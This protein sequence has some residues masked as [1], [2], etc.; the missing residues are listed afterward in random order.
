MTSASATVGRRS[1]GGR[2]AVGVE[3]K[4]RGKEAKEVEEAKKVQGK[5][6]DSGKGEVKKGEED[7]VPSADVASDVQP[8]NPGPSG[9]IAHATTLEPV[10]L[11]ANTLVDT[12]N[13][14]VVLP[15]PPQLDNL[16][17][18]TD[19]PFAEQHL[20]SP[21][22]SMPS[23]EES[24]VETK[25]PFPSPVDPTPVVTKDEGATA[26]NSEQN[27]VLEQVEEPIALVQEMPESSAVNAE[28][29][30]PNEQKTVEAPSLA[31]E[32]AP[33][34]EPS[35][36]EAAIPT[37]TQES[38]LQPL[39]D[40]LASATTTEEEEQAALVI[41]HAYKLHRASIKPEPA[42]EAEGEGKVEVGNAGTA[43]A[44]HALVEP[45]K[46]EQHEEVHGS[47]E[48]AEEKKEAVVEQVE[49]TDEQVVA[50]SGNESE[51]ATG[52]V[53][54]QIEQPSANLAV[55]PI[56]EPV[57]TTEPEQIASPVVTEQSIE[58]QQK[59]EEESPE[60]NATE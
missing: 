13:A 11:I 38:P 49:A 6:T 57:L 17:T 37:T 34:I 47:K 52:A 9:T 10:V 19:E 28:Q 23:E 50:I 35:L 20:L 12:L 1:T 39:D 59:V 22:L 33:P 45:K 24:P 14:P 15:Q 43:E 51:P 31:P 46:E 60:P 25:E 56:A 54:Q 29:R 36:L 16:P 2:I 7:A 5:K 4:P 55:E 3:R 21:V 40:L 42:V 41:Q 30:E 53:A 8:A 48:Q 44:T 26:N 58:E 32:P 27:P 18:P